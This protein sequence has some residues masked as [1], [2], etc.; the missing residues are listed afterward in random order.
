MTRGAIGFSSS[1][2]AYSSLAMSTRL[3]ALATPIILQN[4]RRAA[5]GTPRR[6]IPASVGNLG[7]SHPFK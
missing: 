3:S 2:M 7:S 6:R 4:V 1:R 5:G